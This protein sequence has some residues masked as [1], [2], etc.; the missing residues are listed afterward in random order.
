M[1]RRSFLRVCIALPVAAALPRMVEL[2][3]A[4]APAKA[5]TL[6][7]LTSNGDLEFATT[8]DMWAFTPDEIRLLGPLKWVASTSM[9]VTGIA[10]DFHDLAFHGWRLG[11]RIFNV[12]GSP[13]L[14]LMAD[15]MYTH[16][17]LP[18]AYDSRPAPTD[19]RDRPLPAQP[20]SSV[21]IDL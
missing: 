12:G 21:D 4:K 19:A 10:I 6:I 7:F 13:I 18:I 8:Q 9:V 5:P 11:R 3:P 20:G 2:A 14:M 15:S 16:V 17:K 1:N